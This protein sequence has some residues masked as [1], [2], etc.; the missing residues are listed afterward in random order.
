MHTA[1]ILSLVSQCIAGNEQAIDSL[2]HHYELGVFRLAL[3]IVDDPMEAGEITQ[4]V[5]IS[6]INGLDKY[7]EQQSFKA[8]LYTITVNCSRSHLRKRRAREKLQ[9]TLTRLF[10]VEYEKQNFTRRVCPPK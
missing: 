9:A 6:A 10:R 5:F 1:D 8:W 7:K 4:E 3:S 2:F